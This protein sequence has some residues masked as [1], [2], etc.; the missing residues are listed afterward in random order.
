MFWN[1]SL[2][3]NLDQIIRVRGHPTFQPSLVTP[4]HGDRRDPRSRPA[5]SSAKAERLCF[6]NVAPRD[7]TGVAALSMP[8]PGQWTPI[9]TPGFQVWVSFPMPA[10]NEAHSVQVTQ[11]QYPCSTS[12]SAIELFLAFSPAYH[13]AFLFLF[14]F[15]GKDFF[16]SLH[17]VG[18]GKVEREPWNAN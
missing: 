17:L 12:G 14:Y 3:T 6:R 2:Q 16:K 9:P 18:I 11:R 7:G 1:F 13:L 10:L 5:G 8:F 15:Y 4:T